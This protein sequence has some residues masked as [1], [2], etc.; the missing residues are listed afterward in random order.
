MHFI[1]WGAGHYWLSSKKAV[2]NE[3]DEVIGLMGVSFPLP[4]T[5][6]DDFKRMIEHFNNLNPLP[7]PVKPVASPSPPRPGTKSSQMEDDKNEQK[8]PN[9]ARYRSSQRIRFMQEI[10]D[11]MLTSAAKSLA[12]KKLINDPDRAS[13]NDSLAK[14][15]HEPPHP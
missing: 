10:M 8:F 15:R 1:E 14:N 11:R 13:S 5:N 3:N 2:R 9:H 12:N 7:D 6:V 4:E